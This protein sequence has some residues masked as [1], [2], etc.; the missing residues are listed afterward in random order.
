MKP[1]LL[2]PRVRIHNANA[3][4]SPYTIGFPAMTAWLGFVHALQ[5]KLRSVDFPN[6]DLCRTAVACHSC[7]VQIYKGPH[8]YN[9]SIIGTANPLKKKGN[10]FERPPFIEEPRC[11]LTVSLL[12]ELSH[13]NPEDDNRFLEAV[14]NLIPQFKVAGGDIEKIGT[15][16]VIYTDEDDPKTISRAIRSLMPGYVII[17]RSDLLKGSFTDG[18]DSLDQL[19]EALAVNFIPTEKMATETDPQ[20]SPQ[21]L[22]AGWLIPQAIGFKDLSGPV[23]VQHQRSYDCE[24]HFA[25]SVVTLCEFKMSFHFRNLDDIMWSYRTIPEHGLYLCANNNQWN[26]EQH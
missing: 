20:W 14:R 13:M 21:R 17:D 8:D 12:V 19:L 16:Q 4:S 1:Y 15:L 9:Y 11:H 2:I 10:E 7:D 24:H 25:E 26:N 5:R 3:M 6:I 23:T 22:Q 18:K